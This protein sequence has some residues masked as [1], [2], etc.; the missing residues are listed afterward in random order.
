MRFA[1]HDGM[2]TTENRVWKSAM[3]QEHSRR[4]ARRRAMQ[5]RRG[6]AAAMYLGATP[7]V[8][9]EVRVAWAMEGGEG[10]LAYV[11]RMSYEADRIW[12]AV[13]VCGVEATCTWVGGAR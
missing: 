1:I 9:R 7:A 10:W 8:K 5:A 3:T 11:C 13:Q 6:V 4:Y 12:A 2:S